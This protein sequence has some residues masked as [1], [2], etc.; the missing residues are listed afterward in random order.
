M[1]NAVPASIATFFAG[2]GA[3]ALARPEIVHETFGT[4]NPTADAR[5]EVRAVYG[6]YGLA[7]AGMVAAALRKPEDRKGLLM[8][9]G[10][11]TLGMMGGRAAGIAIERP[12]RLY[13]VWFYL[14]LEAAMG[15]GLVKAA[16]S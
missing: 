14:A 15:A 1:S 12:Q 5:N 10:I 9:S 11:A 8:G 3:V 16:T 2:M 7:V 13:P 4:T 6:G